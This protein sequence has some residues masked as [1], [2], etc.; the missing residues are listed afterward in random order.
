MALSSTMLALPAVPALARRMVYRVLPTPTVTR[1]PPMAMASSGVMAS[2][3]STTSLAEEVVL[4]AVTL[5]ALPTRTAALKILA[6][7]VSTKRTP[8]MRPISP[9]YQSLGS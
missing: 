5:V 9:S 3:M 7:V 2:S 4:L 6:S 8:A 1:L